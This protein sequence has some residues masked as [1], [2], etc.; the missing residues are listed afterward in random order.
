MPPG[1][2][3]N[4]N[5]S[6]LS[7]AP[8]RQSGGSGIYDFLNSGSSALATVNP[9]LGLGVKFGGKLLKEFGVLGDS[10]EDKMRKN[11][12]TW[13]NNSRHRPAVTDAQIKSFAP[14]I[15]GLSVPGANKIAR[16]ASR[17]GVLRG[18]GEGEIARMTRSDMI[19]AFSRLKQFQLEANTNKPYQI[20]NALRGLV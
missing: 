6:F 13:L 16:S 5:N 11:I 20:A 19:R 2:G 1:I 17:A 15:E 10:F 3:Y 14:F 8:K 4:N 12:A 18:Q 9:L 7:N